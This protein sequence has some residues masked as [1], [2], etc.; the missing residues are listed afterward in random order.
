MGT[1]AEGPTRQRSN[2]SGPLQVL[3]TLGAISLR[4]IDAA[5]TVDSATD[6]D[7]F[8]A[9]VEQVLCPKLR[10]GDVVVMENLSA[11]KV[12]GIRARIE[13]CRAQLLYLPPYLP[14]LNLIEKAWSKFKQFLRAA[15]ARSQE[16]LDQAITD[17]IKTIT[18]ENA[19]AW[20]KHCG[21]GY[22]DLS[23]DLVASCTSSRS[24]RTAAP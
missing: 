4:G 21:Y 11:H 12:T 3:T 10:P 7:V 24:H 5:R 1:S 2:A 9:Y 17:A 23:F 14:D 20:F 16:A 22:T 8:R 13:A 15:K 19:A 6:G 18:P